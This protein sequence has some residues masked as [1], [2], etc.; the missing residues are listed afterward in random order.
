MANILPFSK[1][2]SIVKP[3]AL[4]ET[5][6]EVFHYCPAEVRER[7][8]RA[9][10]SA[11]NSG[12]DFMAAMETAEEIVRW[13]GH[14]APKQDA[15]LEKIRCNEELLRNT[16]RLTIF[17]ERQQRLFRDRLRV[18]TEIIHDRMRGYSERAIMESIARADRVIS[19][20]GTVGTALRF[21]L[22][23]ELYLQFIS[24]C[25]AHRSR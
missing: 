6:N 13:N 20:N 23:E 18:A 3:E 17:K 10:Q 22:G 8:F 25:S 12:S 4:A 24:D 14:E 9:A 1:K 16:K 7:A 15:E 5:I 19:A 2:P 21:G 11:I